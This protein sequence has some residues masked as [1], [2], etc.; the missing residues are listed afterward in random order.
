MQLSKNII[1]GAAVLSYSQYGGNQSTIDVQIARDDK[2][3]DWALRV[4]DEIIGYWPAS[5]FPQLR[6]R[7][8]LIQWGGEIV[9]SEPEILHTAT[10]MGSGHFP[11]EGP[12]KAA[13]FHTI[14]IR[15]E[16]QGSF[17]DAYDLTP[18]R[19]NANCYEITMNS[20]GN[21]FE[22][23][24]FFFGGLGYSDTCKKS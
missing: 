1:L 10:E 16:G 6:E 7:A 23:V 4:V 2:T 9:D 12:G 8:D 21:P 3:G 5:L 18:F 14:Q 24:N 19:T 17:V 22:K 11:N 15:K 13:F 20:Y